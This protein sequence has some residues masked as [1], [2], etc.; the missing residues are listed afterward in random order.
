MLRRTEDLRLPRDL[1]EEREEREEREL[2]RE[3]EE[4][5]LEREREDLREER[6]L[7]DLREDLREAFLV[8]LQEATILSFFF[9]FS[10]SLTVLGE[11]VL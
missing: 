8:G 4:R 3:R 2:E 10:E 9:W 1:R 6:E 5:E 7:E 11:P